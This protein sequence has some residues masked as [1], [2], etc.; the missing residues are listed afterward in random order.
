M[1]GW[2]DTPAGKVPQVATKLS[3]RDRRGAARVRLNIRRMDYAIP[4]GLYAVGQ[5][6]Q[7]SPVLASANY[8][9]SFDY[10][11][12][13][14]DG[15]AAWILV[16]DTKGVN[17]WCA[18]G[19]GTFGTGEI[20]DQIEVTALASVVAHRTLITPQLGAPGVAA[21]EVRKRSGFRVVYGPVRAKDTRAFLE[22]GMQATPEMRR[23]RFDLR[24]RLV[25]IPLELVQ[26]LKYTLFAVACLFIFSGLSRDGYDSARALAHG[27]RAALLLFLSVLGGCAV[28]PILLP[29][30]PGRAFSSKGATIGILLA[31]CVVLL[32][33][34]PWEGTGGRLET[35]SWL[36]MMPAVSAFLAMNFTGASTYTSLSGVKR[37]MRTAGPTQFT[38]AVIGLAFW[39]VGRFF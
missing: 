27:S 24:D 29:W 11:R 17:V 9:L 25:I 13:E 12:R 7:D 8:K 38:A 6:T 28:T 37:E 18:A 3:S 33:W 26:A 39:I 2:L 31:C 30:L 4:P 16:L 35:A 5:P 32:R 21:H 14:L 1:V 36:L 19:K 15:L 23:V 10:L 22:A 20:I 34:I